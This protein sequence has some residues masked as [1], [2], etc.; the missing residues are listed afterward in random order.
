MPLPRLALAPHPGALAVIVVAF[1]LPGLA[2][3]DPW[4]THDVIGI[5]IVHGM[6]TGSDGLVPRVAGMLWL[7]DGPLYHWAALGF[8]RVLGGLLEFHS[9]ARLASGAFMLAA[10]WLL[11]GAAR[12]WSAQ[13]DR[14]T[15]AAAAVLLL[16][17]SVGL[18]VHSHEALPEIAALA[19]VCGALAALPHVRTRPLLSGAG[20]GAGLGVA[21]L[22]A[23]W[24]APAALG[25]AAA[26]AVLACDEWRTRG[27][28]AFIVAAG[29]VALL[30]TASWP[31][32]LALR[33]P[34]LFATWAGSAF[35]PQGVLS[36]NVRYFL[37]TGSW[38]AW[39]AWPL[40]F[41]AA[42]ASRRRWREARIFVPALA[43][44]LMLGAVIYWGPPHDVNLIAM[45]APLALLGAQ[46]LWTL[47]RG[48]A[49]ALDWFGVLCF[50]F[51]AALVWLGYVAMMTGVPPKIANNFLK[52]APGFQA[53]FDAANLV[54][55]IALTLGWLYVVLYPPAGPLRTA[56]RWA[57][58]VVLLWGLFAALW[59]PWADYQK[60]Y[61]TVAL[62]LRSRIPVATPCV[63][64]RS[65]GVSQAAALQYHADLQTRPFDV[66][67]PSACP[68]LLVQGSPRHEY[69]APG[70][71]WVKLADVGRPGDKAERY[72]LYQLRR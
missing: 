62:Q 24:M 1:L 40:A 28:L 22:S 42:W 19:G 52:T 17:G 71:G 18:M 8:G 53:T 39:P 36:D 63:A 41:W 7:Y 43:A 6:A 55:A 37:S 33:S 68:L 45:L 70:A 5:A 30:L 72:R 26:A 67:S 31:L 16:L 10:F 35:Q 54:L 58:G 11:Y 69:D 20:F 50:A 65:L 51:F 66:L 9:A 12:D 3:H 60:S 21:A 56:L 59:M 48:A 2:S 44:V 27:G 25:L 15:T 57:A 14:R 61:R 34:E 47:R 29:L 38:F 23:T 32:A 49:G 4:K 64:Q 13:A 46:G